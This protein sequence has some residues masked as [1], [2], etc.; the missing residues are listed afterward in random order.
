[1]YLIY[2]QWNWEPGYD[3][4]LATTR[5]AAARIARQLRKAYDGWITMDNYG[6]KKQIGRVVILPIK[7]EGEEEGAP[8]DRA[9]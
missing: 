5:R 4:R 6:T 3:Y 8:D 1:M 7:P 9:N 2:W